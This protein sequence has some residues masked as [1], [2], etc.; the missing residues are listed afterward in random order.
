MAKD[1]TAALCAVLAMCAL[2]T[3]A[4][5]VRHALAPPPTASNETRAH[6]GRVFVL[7]SSGGA[8]LRRARPHLVGVPHTVVHDDHT[9]LVGCAAGAPVTPKEARCTHAH[10]RALR[11]IANMSA[12]NT[13]ALVLEDDFCPMPAIGSGVDMV[14][15]VEGAL[16]RLPRGAG[17]HNLGRCSGTSIASQIATPSHLFQGADTC[18]TVGGIFG[19]CTHAYAVTPSMAGHLLTRIARTRCAF[20]VDT[21]IDFDTERRNAYSHS[22]CTYSE[23]PPS[24]RAN[25]INGMFGQC[26][27][28]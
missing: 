14:R 17:A 26:R 16:A 9:K 12:A 4:T 6:V 24:A 11:S 18:S 13:W 2:A 27:R 20:P 7:T 1:R 23:K 15:A 21:A 25:T 10:A 5:F 28:T 22:W 19:R 3:V 8:R